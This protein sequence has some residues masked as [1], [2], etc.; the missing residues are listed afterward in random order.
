MFFIHIYNF[1]SQLLLIKHYMVSKCFLALFVKAYLWSWS[2]DLLPLMTSSFSS[3]VASDGICSYCYHFNSFATLSILT[4]PSISIKLDYMNYFFWHEQLQNIVIE[5]GLK[6]FLDI[7][8]LVPT[9][10]ISTPILG[11]FV[12]NLV[13]FACN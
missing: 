1:P 4:S 13:S 11:F 7:S 2:W 10:F 9:E 6:K 12:V 5:Y 3:T 8:Q